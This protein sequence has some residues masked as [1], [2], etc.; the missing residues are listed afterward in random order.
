MLELL[1]DARLLSSCPWPNTLASSPRSLECNI[2][3][4]RIRA[5]AT[6]CK[7]SMIPMH[8]EPCENGVL[9]RCRSNS[10][11]FFEAAVTVVMIHLECEF[12][13]I[14]LFSVT[15][16]MPLL[17]VQMFSVAHVNRSCPQHLLEWKL[18]VLYNRSFLY[19]LNFA[20]SISHP[21]TKAES[22]S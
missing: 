4:L 17:T 15:L 13:K 14:N 11:S 8:H 12:K 9:A 19:M 7:I 20:L 5:Y 16:V 3:H 22:T 1:S 18:P 2:H 6:V 21:E 10:N